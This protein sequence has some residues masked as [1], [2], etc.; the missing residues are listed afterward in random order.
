[1]GWTVISVVVFVILQLLRSRCQGIL[2]N[3]IIGLVGAAWA[4]MTFFVIPVLIVEG[5]GPIEAIK[6]S[7]GY[8]RRT[9]GEQ[10][11]S[12]F[13]FALL[14]IGV[15]LIAAL[16]IV[17]LASVSPI[18]A[19][20]CGRADYR[21]RDRDCADAGRH[22]QGGRCTNTPPRASRPNSS[23]RNSWAARMFRA[24]QPI[25]ERCDSVAVS[26]DRHEG[27]FVAGQVDAPAGTMPVF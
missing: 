26:S 8:C 4:Y 19:I 10:L 15:V 6:R 23:H 25:A 7:A 24:P 3:I 13:G 16:P 1:M 5:V 18:A 17:A 21:D 12:N 9:W 11:V 2:C 27:V 20:H 14:Q 22:L